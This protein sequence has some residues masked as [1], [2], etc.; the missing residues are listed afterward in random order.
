LLP[1]SIYLGPGVYGCR[2]KLTKLSGVFVRFLA[3]QALYRG[4]F[5]NV[6]AAGSS[7][8][9]IRLLRCFRTNAQVKVKSL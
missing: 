2:L 4:R 9:D 1:R 3:L 6:V 5:A 8:Q 7:N